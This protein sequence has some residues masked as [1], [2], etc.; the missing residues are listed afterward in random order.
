MRT[1]RVAMRS[2]TR[3]SI[4]AALAT[5]VLGALGFCAAAQAE[6]K[7]SKADMKYKNVYLE[8]FKVAAAGVDETNPA[9]ALAAAQQACLGAL[10]SSGLF[11]TVKVGPPPKGAAG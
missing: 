6:P 7:L 5:L 2:Q 3:W 8:P 9:P 4:R 1:E 11:D 10:Q